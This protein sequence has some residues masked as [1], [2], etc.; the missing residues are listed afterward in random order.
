M[1]L[2]FLG[3]KLLL[4][5][6]IDINKQAPLET[7]ID[8]DGET[9]SIHEL[10][11]TAFSTSKGHTLAGLRDLFNQGQKELY[12]RATRAFQILHWRR[13]YQ[14]CPK[15]ANPLTRKNTGEMALCCN[16]CKLDYFPRI[17][18]AIIVAITHQDK[19]LLAERP[20]AQ[21]PFYSLIAGF[22]EVGETIENAVRRE[23]HEE[24]G[25][26]I[27]DIRYIKSQPW[28]F[29]SNLMLGFI[30]KAKTT[31][32]FPDGSEVQKAAFF[33]KDNLPSNLP[34]KLSIARYLID[35]WL[36]SEI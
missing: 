29:P 19:I 9:V 8:F 16:M 25:L 36:N 31:E 5:P 1:D 10:N 34:Q 4:N 21:G 13:S 33:P 11:D 3:N 22:V 28:P 26:E 18:P 35:A 12:N 32:I 15:C 2:F 24:I 14:F 7:Y 17:N 30:A 23:V 20:S 27:D 6:A